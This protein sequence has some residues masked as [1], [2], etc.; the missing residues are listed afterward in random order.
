[1]TIATEPQERVGRLPVQRLAALRIEEQAAVHRIAS[2]AHQLAACRVE[3]GRAAERRDRL[4]VYRFSDMQ[5]A[6]IDALE[7]EAV[8]ALRLIHANTPAFTGE[9]PGLAVVA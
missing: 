6:L 7:G 9:R 5:A 4:A 1:V 2:R 8:A 3:L